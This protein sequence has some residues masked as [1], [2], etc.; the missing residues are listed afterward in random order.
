MRSYVSLLS[1]ATYSLQFTA[2]YNY[3]STLLKHRGLE[4]SMLINTV[5]F[6]K[7]FI[8]PHRRDWNFLGV[9]EGLYNQKL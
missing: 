9:G 1:E 5:Q 8:V 7:I 2:V 3:Y 6:Q 4:R